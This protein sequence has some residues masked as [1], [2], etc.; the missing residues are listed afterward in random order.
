[1]SF[2]PQ[3]AELAGDAASRR[4]VVLHLPPA[5]TV[6]R[7]LVVHAPA[8]GE[9]MNKSRRMVAM[10]SRQLAAEGFAV[11]LADPLGCGDSPGDF[12]DA[13]WSGWVQDIVRSLGWLRAEFHRRW[14]GRDE[15][16]CLLWGHRAGALLACAAAAETDVPCSLLLW[17]PATQGR[18]VLQQFLRLLSAGELISGKAQG[19]AAAARA[20]L[21]AGNAVDVAG[22]RLSPALAT[23][24]EAAELVAPA[25]PGRLIAFEVGTREEPTPVLAAALQRWQAAGWQA[26]AQVVAGPA[27][28]QTTEIEDAPALLAATAQALRE[29]WPAALPEA[30]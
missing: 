8:F 10:Q 19:A 15:P 3:F 27:F 18:V 6:P 22:Y 5:G 25:R 14:P 28:W 29:A 13:G 21:A 2:V 17:Q 12:G 7:G 4:F 11:L 9:E 16:P 24:L 23:G 20:A 1:M 30:A 26:Q